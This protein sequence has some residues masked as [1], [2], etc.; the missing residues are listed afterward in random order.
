MPLYLFYTM[1]QKSQNDQK[2]KSRGSCLNLIPFFNIAQYLLFFLPFCLGMCC[3]T[4]G[5]CAVATVAVCGFGSWSLVSHGGMLRQNSPLP[6]TPSQTKVYSTMGE[7]IRPSSLHNP[8]PSAKK[9]V[10][11]ICRSLLSAA[12][13]TVQVSIEP[14]LSTALKDRSVLP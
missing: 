11:Q 12:M 8:T 13:Q 6:R 9:H 2:L 5:R 1:V 10:I 3:F 4:W 7:S 14:H